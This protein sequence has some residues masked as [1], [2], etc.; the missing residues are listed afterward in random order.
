MLTRSHSEGNIILNFSSFLY[1]N[2][3]FAFIFALLRRIAE[4]MLIIPGFPACILLFYC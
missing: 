2:F 3:L 4:D 1:A